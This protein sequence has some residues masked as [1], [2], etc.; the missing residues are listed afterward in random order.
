MKASYKNR[1]VLVEKKEIE[2]TQGQFITGRFALHQEFNQGIP[3]RKQTKETTLWSWLKKLENM[4]NIDIKSYNKY[5]VVTVVNWCLYQ[6]TLTTEPQ[7]NDNRLTAESQQ[8][9]TNKK[10]KKEKKV[11]KDKEEDINNSR[12]QVFDENSIYFQLANRFY[13]NILKN[14]PNH[15]EPNLQK[16]SNDIRLMIERD[17]RT[18]EQIKY[19]IDWVQQDSFEMSNV[20]STDKLRKR[21]D[22][23]A[24]KVKTLAQR[25][26]K[27]DQRKPKAFQSLEDWAEEDG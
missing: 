13:Q 24:M 9:D 26:Q 2:L 12:K 19:L 1:K 11:K 6:E 3:P 21:F 10:V 8:I 25:S 15:K 7:Q 27:N 16:W 18:L 22:Q 20:L 23:L 4:G 14:N 5:S 17:N